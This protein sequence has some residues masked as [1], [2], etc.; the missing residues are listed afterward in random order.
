MLIAASCV[1]TPPQIIRVLRLD[2]RSNSFASTMRYWMFHVMTLSLTTPTSPETNAINTTSYSG[3][4]IHHFLSPDTFWLFGKPPKV[5]HQ[6][7][8]QSTFWWRH[9]GHDGVSNHQPHYCLL[10]RLFGCRSKKT[11][12]LRVTGFCAG[13]HRGP[14]NSPH[15][16]PVTQKMFP[17]DDVIMITDKTYL[18]L[19]C[20]LW[21]VCNCYF[22]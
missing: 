19:H 20:T 22:E 1:I 12:K 14:V 5:A 7:V 13:I 9:N 17:F 3:R 21:G 15:K 11:S 6:S 8:F 10:N 18:T 2:I 4:S 16:W